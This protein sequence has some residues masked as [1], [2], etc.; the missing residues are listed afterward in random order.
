MK[1]ISL[2]GGTTISFRPIQPADEPL[3]YQIYASTRADEMALVS[4]W[5]AEQK[6]TFVRQQFHA[7][8]QYYQMQFADAQYLIV[9]VDGTPAGR[10]YLHQRH[11]EYRIIDITL[12]PTVR[13]KGIGTAILR[14]VLQTAANQQL[15]VRIHVERYNPALQLYKRLG[16]TISSEENPIYYLMT[17]QNA[18]H[19]I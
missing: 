17:W 2:E 4:H 18:P 7:Q 3:L 5:N 14:Q 19:S 15:P 6:D 8:H 1:A 11:D 10:L 13:A 9:W 12:L 16:F